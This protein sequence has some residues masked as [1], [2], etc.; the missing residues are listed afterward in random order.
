MHHS[1]P[2]FNLQ[3]L[4]ELHGGNQR[5]L[6]RMKKVLDSPSDYKVRDPSLETHETREL[7]SLSLGQYAHNN[8]PMHHF[9]YLFAVLGDH[10]TTEKLVRHTLF[11]AYSPSGFSGDEDN[12]EMGAWYVLSA[13]G[14]YALAPGVTDEYVLGAMPLFRRMRLSELGVVIEAPAAPEESPVVSEVRWLSQPLVRR[15]DQKQLGNHSIAFSQLRKGG[16]LHFASPNDAAEES[17][18]TDSCSVNCAP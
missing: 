16:V 14:L 8:Q 5:L 10:R 11:H 9:P 7:L 2:P 15:L 17:G 18:T 6:W 4:L 12:G 3:V 1:F 13:L